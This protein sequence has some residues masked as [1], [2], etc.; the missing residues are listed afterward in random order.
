MTLEH[1]INYSR[2]FF[3]LHLQFKNIC[4]RILRVNSSVMITQISTMDGKIIATE[5]AGKFPREFPLL[6]REELEVATA[7][8][9]IEINIKKTQEDKFG[10]PLFSFTRYRTISR[11]T[12]ILQQGTKN[13]GD[14]VLILTM[15][16]DANPRDL[17]L[18]LADIIKQAP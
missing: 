8:S 11:L 10:P 5:L 9:L 17:E 12:M 18:Q 7:Q 1:I 2:T 14:L 15:K 3:A 13:A 4:R 16:K 6:S